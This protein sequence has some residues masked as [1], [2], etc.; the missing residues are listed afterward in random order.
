MADHHT[1]STSTSSSS[2]LTDIEKQEDNSTDLRQYASIYRS[3]TQRTSKSARHPH[4]LDGAELVNLP[5]RTLGGN[6]NLDEYLEETVSGLI[7]ETKTSRTTGRIEKYELVTWKLN[8]PENPKNWSKAYKWSVKL[9][10]YMLAC[11]TSMLTVYIIGG[12]P[13]A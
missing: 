12:A 13:C 10:M 6:A 2:S 8:D 9:S 1:S 11:S 4:D 5:S 3:Q 7:E